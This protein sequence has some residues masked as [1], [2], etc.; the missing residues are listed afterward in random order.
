MLL[1]VVFATANIEDPDAV[2]S[3][4][5]AALPSKPN[6]A[7]VIILSPISPSRTYVFNPNAHEQLAFTD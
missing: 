3:S 1:S 6:L 7:V 4:L 5:H 2:P